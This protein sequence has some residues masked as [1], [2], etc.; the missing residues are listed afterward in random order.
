M[1]QGLPGQLTNEEQLWLL[2]EV[3][4]NRMTQDEAVEYARERG[5]Q[6]RLEAQQ[7]QGTSQEMSK[8][9][10]KGGFFKKHSFTAGFA[11]LPTAGR[12][13]KMFRKDS[14]GLEDQMSK[15]EGQMPEV[16]K[17]AGLVEDLMKKEGIS[18]EDVQR[19]SLAFS[20]MEVKEG[21]AARS[22]IGNLVK[23]GRMTIQDAMQYAQD[24]GLAEAERT[25]KENIAEASSAFQQRKVYNFTVYKF[26]KHRTS[27]RRILQIDFDIKVLRNIQR[28]NVNN[29]FQFE[30]VT[31]SES[32][33]GL[34][35]FIY[36]E[37]YHEYELN[38]DNLEEKNKI[39]RLLNIIVE[40]NKCEKEG[41]TFQPVKTLPRAQ[42]IIKEG[43]LEKRAGTALLRN[44]WNRRWIRIRQGEL[45]YYKLAEETQTALNI[46][47]LNDESVSITPEG[48]YGFC[49]STNKEHFSFRV[50]NPNQ[51][52]GAD[53]QAIRDEW[54]KVLSRASQDYRR[55]AAHVYDHI[56]TD[57]FFNQATSTTTVHHLTEEVGGLV[58]KLQVELEQL[59]SVLTILDA[60]EA[61]AQMTKLKEIA[62]SL[63]NQ[64]RD[65]GL[66]GSLTD[67]SQKSSTLRDSSDTSDSLKRQDSTDSSEG[68]YMDMKSP[69]ILQKRESG[70]FAVI[71]G[72]DIQKE[73]QETITEEEETNGEKNISDMY[74]KVNKEQSVVPPPLPIKRKKSFEGLIDG[75]KK[76]EDAAV[77][78]NGGGD[79]KAEE[80]QDQTDSSDAKADITT[81]GKLPIDSASL[82]LPPH[83]VPSGLHT[84][85]SGPPTPP[86][87]P[88]L[89]RGKCESPP[90]IGGGGPPTPPSSP[91]KT[92]DM[93]DEISMD[94]VKERLDLSVEMDKTDGADNTENTSPEI[95]EASPV[96]P[97]TSPASPPPPTSPVSPP[98]PI[99]PVSP[100]PPPPP[101]PTSPIPAAPPLPVFNRGSR[102]KLRPFHWTKIPTNMLSKTIWKQAQDRSADISVE[103]LEKNFALTD[104]DSPDS[105]PVK[106]KKKAKLLLDSKMAH[107]LAIF[108]TGFKVGPG[109]FTNKLLII[110]EEEGGLTME[111]INTLRRFLPTS[112]EQELFRSYQGERSELESTDRFMLEMCSVPMVEIRLDLLMVMAEL[113]EQIQDLTPTIHTTLG[114]CQELVQQKHF[115]Q[116]LEYILA[117]GNRIN[118]GT[119]RGAARG[120]RLASLNKL[121]ETYSSDRSSSLLQFVVEQIKQKEPQLLDVSADMSCV[122]RAAGASVKGLMAEMEV[123]TKDLLKAKKHVSYMKKKKNSPSKRDLEFCKEVEDKI[124]LHEKE[125]NALQKQCSTMRDTFNKVLGLY[126]ELPGTDSQ[127]VFSAV[128]EF[129]ASFDIARDRL[130]EEEEKRTDPRKKLGAIMQGSL[131]GAAVKL[132][133]PTSDHSAMLT[134]LRDTLPAMPSPDQDNSQGQWAQSS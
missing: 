88:F 41:E 3:K 70:S 116:V 78:E 30:Q 71:S 27:Q 73:D 129:L 32:A 58:K 82:P 40:Q 68:E 19:E 97:P 69:G 128:S 127:E 95:Q 107:N 94:S 90:P 89:A 85:P 100:P 6:A 7:V 64:L 87:S 132:R 13:G 4:E 102:V 108:L 122:Q 103:V 112:E 86:P 91:F 110:G 81:N 121:S 109:E 63:D 2:T 133:S 105:A 39:L 125:V 113:P 99:S 53:V 5:A 33:E 134:S 36:F 115:H 55:S 26:F 38:A 106:V 104:R 17:N 123:M 43:E 45:S 35:F 65:S 22:L 131:A 83:L 1:S 31:G 46:I 47:H 59:Q 14:K 25:E 52:A 20:S 126:G 96:S 28:G 9:K 114:A 75:D 77:E 34:R 76:D 74:S 93:H 72:E 29:T 118:M 101:L 84:P 54:F 119:T 61:T 120:F 23:R 15:G 67:V 42:A 8:Q 49:I 50:P 62:S 124:S 51:K 117:V 11:K 44:Q 79:T 16:G 130:R 111:Q 98:P 18:A 48:D 37:D 12:A 92:E 10:K 66:P 60:Q 57:D 21:D 56:L 24:H 80:Q